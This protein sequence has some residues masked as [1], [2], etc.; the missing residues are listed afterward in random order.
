[1][2]VK[3]HKHKVKVM[4]EPVVGTKD[5]VLAIHKSMDVYKEMMMVSKKGADARS[6]MSFALLEK[7]LES[8]CDSQM[9]MQAL[10]WDMVLKINT[11]RSVS[12][13]A[14]RARKENED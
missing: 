4:E 3:W 2:Q 7:F 6:W 5:V 12:L 1:M 10:L 14:K 8:E 9:T 13:F 11:P